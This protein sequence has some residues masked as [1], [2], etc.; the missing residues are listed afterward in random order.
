MAET[1]PYARERCSNVVTSA[2][3]ANTTENVTAN[4]PLIEIIAK[5]HH[6]FIVISGIGAHVKNT[7]MSKK[8]FLPHMSERAPMRGALRNDKM[9]L[10]PM[11]SP[12]IKNV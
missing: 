5:N 8:N 9:P 4:M 2:T 10:I 11:T 6:V 3:Y 1:K 7:V 12:F